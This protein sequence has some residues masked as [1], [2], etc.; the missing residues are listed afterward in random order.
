MGYE[1]WEAL[2]PVQVIAVLGPMR[3]AKGLIKARPDDG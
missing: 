1:G 2:N 3:L